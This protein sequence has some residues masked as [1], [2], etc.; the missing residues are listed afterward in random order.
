MLYNKVG[1][2]VDAN[3]ILEVK[4]VFA[5][6]AKS[7]GFEFDSLNDHAPLT[8]DYLKRFQVI[9]WNNNTNGAAPGRAKGAD[10]FIGQ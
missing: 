7:K 6:M 3:A 1:G 8:L 5:R 2:W 10:G 4:D 9:I